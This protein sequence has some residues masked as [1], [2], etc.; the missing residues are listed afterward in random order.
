MKISACGK[1]STVAYWVV[2]ALAIYFACVSA[3]QGASTFK[4]EVIGKG[5]PMIL[6]PGLSSSGDVWKSTVIHYQ[7]HYQCHVIT[8]AGFAGVPPLAEDAFLDHV[9]NDLIAYI[10]ENHLQK[11]VIVGHSL[12]GFL[13]MWIASTEPDLVGKIIIV[14]ALPFLP[15]AFYPTITAQT[16]APFASKMKNQMLQQTDDQYK[17][18]QKM[19]FRSLIT[20]TATADAASEWGRNSDKATVAQVVFEMQTTD[21][22]DE[23]SKITSPA[24]VFA[25]WIAYAPNQTH[26]GITEVF[27]SQYAEMKNYKLVVEDHSKHF[28]MLDDPQGFFAEMDNFLASGH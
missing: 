21:L 18:S 3:S 6:I 27:K 25:T 24:L 10:K 7:E 23:I 20:D 26:D 2:I 9:K 8:L 28:V 13:T 1:K 11:P 15:A 12:G 17:A 4:V 5:D 14:D 16:S 22:R 19:I